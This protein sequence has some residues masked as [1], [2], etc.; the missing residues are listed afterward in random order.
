MGQGGCQGAVV[1]HP[2]RKK[3]FTMRMSA[4]ERGRLEWVA[5]H[6]KLSCAQVIRMLLKR[7]DRER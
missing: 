3:L 2:P 7:E 5:R 4:V 6:Y 1:K